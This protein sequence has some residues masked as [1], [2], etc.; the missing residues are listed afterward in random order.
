M[1]LNITVVDEATGEIQVLARSWNRIRQPRWIKVFAESF[2][3]IM[4]DPTLRDI[5]TRILCYL[6][7]CMDTSNIVYSRVSFIA[8]DLH[9]SQRAV[10]AA[11]KRLAAAHYL[12]RLGSRV[13]RINHTV[14]WRSSNLRWSELRPQ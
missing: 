14:A 13:L 3:T 10:Y 11:L 1:A 9:C 12:E 2:A 4:T 5:D 7:S 8:D 6:I